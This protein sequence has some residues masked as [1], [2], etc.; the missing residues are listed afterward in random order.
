M[1]NLD[2]GGENLSLTSKSE[3]QR[4]LERMRTTSTRLHVL[5][6]SLDQVLGS[7]KRPAGA[8]AG[9]TGEST[10]APQRP[11][12]TAATSLFDGLEM[13]AAE[14]DRVADQLEKRVKML[15]AWF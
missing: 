9:S 4:M 6:G 12:M 7:I 11:S 10:R 13:L 1:P 2:K 15:E 3:A 5:V 14:N 8:T